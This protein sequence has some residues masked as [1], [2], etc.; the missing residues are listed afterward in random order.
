[1]LMAYLPRER[2]IVVI[3]VYEPGRAPHMFLRQFV[4]D[5]KKRKNLRVD[6]IIPLHEK[7]VTYEQ[8][9]KEAAGS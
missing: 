3:D 5:L 1:M 6:R 2:A 9:L 8:M 7:I 4:E